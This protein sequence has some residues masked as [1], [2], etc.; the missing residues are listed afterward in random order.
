MTTKLPASSV[1]SLSCQRHAD[2]NSVSGMQA[3]SRGPGL[4]TGTREGLVSTVIAMVAALIFGGAA[5]VWFAPDDSGWLGQ[6]LRM[7]GGSMVMSALVSISGTL[8]SGRNAIYWGVGMPLLVYAAGAFCAFL[9][10][11]AGAAM[12]LYGAPLVCGLSVARGVLVSFALD[13]RG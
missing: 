6:V 4:W 13:R 1:L 12:F 10:G 11:H 7:G 9:S 5:G 8:L 3:F 2:S